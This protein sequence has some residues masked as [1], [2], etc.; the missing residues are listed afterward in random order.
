M[1]F[2]GVWNG[3]FGLF[4][5]C[6]ADGNGLATPN[7][8]PGPSL[9]HR[10]PR[11]A[12]HTACFGRFA[13]AT[14]DAAESPFGLCP[15]AFCGLPCA[16]GVTATLLQRVGVL[17]PR[18]IAC[19]CNSSSTQ[20]WG[21]VASGRMGLQGRSKTG[22]PLFMHGVGDEFINS[23]ARPYAITI[24]SMHE[25]DGFISGCYPLWWSYCSNFTIYHFLTYKNYVEK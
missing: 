3:Q 19:V 2:T 23:I 10:I 11:S 15:F 21:Q 7:R 4:S 20:I 6:S 24:I 25:E 22:L 16:P 5:Q 17:T 8:G 1:H 12:P 13:P 14:A 18:G 9:E